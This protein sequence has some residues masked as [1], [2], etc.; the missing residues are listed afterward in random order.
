VIP[1][2]PPIFPVNSKENPMTTSHKCTRCTIVEGSWWEI[3]PHINKQKK[4]GHIVFEEVKV[5][6]F[7]LKATLSTR[8]YP[9]CQALQRED[10]SD[11]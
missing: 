10:K 8:A 4:L 6:R 9:N 11:T 5:G 3:K 1:F 2:C 7:G